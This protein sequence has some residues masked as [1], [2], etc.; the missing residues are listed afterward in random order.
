VTA[1]A[2]RAPLT[3]RGRRTR[4]ALLAAA[5]EVFEEQGFGATRMDDIAAAAGTSHGTVYTYFQTKED[6]LEAVV[7]RVIDDLLASLRASTAPDPV[8]RVREANNRYLVASAEHARLLRVV[9]EASFSD[10]RFGEVLRQLRTTHITRVAA[11]IRKLQREGAASADLDAQA[12][13]AA[14]CAMV[15]GFSRHYVTDD[16]D[17]LTTLWARAL[18]LSTKE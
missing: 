7:Q 16:H 3:E 10:A 1:T 8:E 4:E 15:E 12:T 9:Q 2:D 18:G 11:A 6:L 17:T 13:A 5:R 14:L